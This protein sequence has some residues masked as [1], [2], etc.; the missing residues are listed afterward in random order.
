MAQ[1]ANGTPLSNISSPAAPSGST[2]NRTPIEPTI[3]H[4]DFKQS[5]LTQHFIHRAEITFAVPAN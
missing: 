2:Y 3:D 5:Q 1:P 4:K